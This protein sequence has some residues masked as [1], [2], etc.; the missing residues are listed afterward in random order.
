MPPIQYIV[1]GGHRLSRHDRAVRQQE[2]GAADH[3]RRAS[4]RASGDAR[5]RAA[6]PRHRDAGRTGPL[7]R[8]RPPNGA[9]TTR[10]RSTPRTS[11]PP[12][13]IRTCARASAPR[14]C[15]RGRCSRAAARSRCRRPAATSSAGAASTRIFWPSSSSAPPSPRPTGWNSARRAER[16][17]R[18]PRRAQRHRDRKRAGRGRRRARHHLSAQCRLRAACAGSRAFPGRARREDR[19]HRHQHDGRARAGDARRGELYDPARSHRGRLADRAGRGDPLA[20]AHRARRR[21]ASALDP[22]GV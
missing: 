2:F 17:R 10:F 3:R 16:R 9:S 13:S 15:S 1:E 7:G 14:S 8:R 4:D 11:A 18:L 21:R 19:G 12:I 20:A 5:Q 6:D 22:D